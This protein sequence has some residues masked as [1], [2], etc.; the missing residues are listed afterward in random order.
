MERDMTPRR[1]WIAAGSTTLTGL[2]VLLMTTK[3]C[4]CPQVSFVTLVQEVGW[5]N[6]FERLVSQLF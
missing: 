4:A 1:T 5:R 6:A 3:L 2:G